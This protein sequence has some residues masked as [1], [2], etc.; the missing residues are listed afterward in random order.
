MRRDLDPIAGREMLRLGL[1][2]EPQPRRSGQQHDP[3]RLVLVVPEA[4]RARLAEG[5]DALDTQTGAGGERLA[6]FCCARV[7]Q[8][9]EQIHGPATASA[10]A[11]ARR[12]PAWRSSRSLSDIA[13]VKRRCGVQRAIIASGSGQ[14]P[15][16]SPAA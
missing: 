7:G 2:G 13:G 16:V 10:P 15:R 11:M 14:S 9:T 4:R 1:V 12:Q 3:F 6:D 8:I 5:D